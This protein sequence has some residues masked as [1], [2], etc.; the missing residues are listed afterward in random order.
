MVKMD[1]G[2]N[3][4]VYES[5]SVCHKVQN[6]ENSLMRSKNGKSVVNIFN[7]YAHL[8]IQK[9][10]QRFKLGSLFSHHEIVLV[11]FSKSFHL[12][13]QSLLLA[14]KPCISSKHLEKNSVLNY[15]ICFMLLTSSCLLLFYELIDCSKSNDLNSHTNIASPIH[16]ECIII[17]IERLKKPLASLTL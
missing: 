14:H 6:I 1:H 11:F 17:C 4:C 3:L 8:C 7:N 9:K 5:Y 13:R 2:A 12:K 10:N 16:P 15:H